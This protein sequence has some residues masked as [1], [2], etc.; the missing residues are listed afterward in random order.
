MPLNIFP[1]LSESVDGHANPRSYNREG[2]GS[3]D[4]EARNYGSAGT[5][6]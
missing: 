3:G 6:F 2:L 1:G 4:D 5:V